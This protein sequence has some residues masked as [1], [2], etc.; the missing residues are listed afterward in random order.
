[1]RRMRRTARRNS[2]SES[3]PGPANSG[4]PAFRSVATER[5]IFDSGRRPRADGADDPVELAALPHYDEWGNYLRGLAAVGL[6]RGS[7]G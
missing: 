5:D 4:S 3:G 6:L 1:M 2:G 7:S